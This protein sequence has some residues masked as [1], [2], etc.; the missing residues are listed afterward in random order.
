MS[1]QIKNV[2]VFCGSYAGKEPSFTEGAKQLANAF[3][4]HNLNLVYGGSNMG[5]M[6]AI[7]DEM[8]AYGGYVMGVIPQSLVDREVAHRGLQELHIVQSMHERK[9]KMEKLSDAFIALPGGFG[10]LDELCEIITWG[11]LGFHRKPFA[12]L[13]TGN[14]FDL[15]IEFLQKSVDEC[16]IDKAHLDLLICESEP[17]KLVERLFQHNPNY[18]VKWTKDHEIK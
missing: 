11:Q 15:F 3:L 4:K 7:A 9:A 16:F 1:Y 12:I 10:T 18:K 14:Y 5:L 17:E 8:L 13:N 2:C 6:G